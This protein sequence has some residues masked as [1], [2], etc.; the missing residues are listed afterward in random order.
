MNS[1]CYCP[2]NSGVSL[3]N[4]F[5]Y[6]LLKK[7]T[8][9]VDLNLLLLLCWYM[10]FYQISPLHPDKSG[11]RS[12]WQRERFHS[13]SSGSRERYSQY[14]L[15]LNSFWFFNT[16]YI[17]VLT[18]QPISFLASSSVQPSATKQIKGVRYLLRGR[19]LKLLHLQFAVTCFLA[20]VHHGTGKCI[21]VN[22]QRLF[23]PYILLTTLL[24]RLCITTFLYF[25][26]KKYI[27]FLT[28]CQ[29]VSVLLS[30]QDTQSGNSRKYSRKGHY[31]FIPLTRISHLGRKT[32]KK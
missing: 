8:I 12:R 16:W 22:N 32:R 15:R 14:L 19:L 9:I 13:G 24:S 1:F 23:L 26:Q 10:L 2:V 11:F 6:T 3:Y 27:L 4:I 20:G 21:G 29:G 17:S 25:C 30:I 5:N 18:A 7:K 31:S 28:K